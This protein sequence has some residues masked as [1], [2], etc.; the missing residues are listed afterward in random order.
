MSRLIRW[1]SILAVFIAAVLFAG[2]FILYA[3]FMEAGP[4][5]A[6]TNLVIPN[7]IGVDGISKLLQAKRI[8]EY[9]ILFRLGARLVEPEIPLRAG[10]FAIPKKS[11]AK[12]V[13]SI[14]RYA[15]TVVRRL[16]IAEGLS[17]QE[18]LV[19]V[20]AAEGL[21]GTL[22]RPLGDGEALPETYHYSYGDSRDEIVDRMRQAMQQIISQSWAR[23]RS[24]LPL[25]TP[26]EALILASIVEKETGRAEER[27]RVA[28]VFINRLK[29][30][31]RLQS[32]PTVVYAMTGGARTLD[33]SLTR[34]DLKFA[35]PFNTYLYK[36]LPP[37][38]ISNPGAAAIEATLNPMP[39]DEL[40]FVADGKGGHAFAAT[41]R[42]HNR[43]VARWRRLKKESGAAPA[44]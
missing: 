32:D 8:V 26:M 36:G 29:K 33:R 3:K 18:V 13:L 14:L 21:Q 10:E 34:A 15:K 38:P 41:L 31:M 27:G 30:G 23:R 43:N 4:L 11:S 17:A 19:R 7:G 9:P 39:T 40:Y 37:G 20:L 5:A 25:A 6:D 24:D 35:S 22:S 44:P 16:T 1:I 42:Q 12:D 28:G 2:G